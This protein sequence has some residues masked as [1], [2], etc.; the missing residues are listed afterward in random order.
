MARYVRMIPDAPG[1]PRFQFYFQDE[2][3]FAG[4]E[5]RARIAHLLRSY[6]NHPERY[7][8]KKLGLHRYAVKMHGYDDLVA[9]MEAV[10]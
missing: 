8:I 10:P 6:R 7:E 5:K 9:I 3:Q 4:Y 1:K 2:P